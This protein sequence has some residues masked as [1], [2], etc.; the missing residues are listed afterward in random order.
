MEPN[1]VTVEVLQ[2]IR[3]EVRG[4]RSDVRAMDGDIKD[5]RV[6]LKEV[7]RRQTESEMHLATELVGVASAVFQVHDILRDDRGDR[8]TVQEHERRISA[9][10]KRLA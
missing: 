10:E 9:L 3:D 2:S 5:V 7:Q 6:E 1:D 8:S 4:L